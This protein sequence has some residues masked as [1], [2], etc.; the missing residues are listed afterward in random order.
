MLTF[1]SNKKVVTPTELA[2]EQVGIGR[3]YYRRVNMY[4]G[5]EKVGYL[6]YI[7]YG[8]DQWA[9]VRLFITRKTIF[10]SKPQVHFYDNQPDTNAED[11]DGMT[12]D[13]AMQ[14]LEELF[15][16]GLDKYSLQI[17]EK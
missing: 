14:Q 12:I 4:L 13:V 9:R 1:K 10:Q 17:K 11:I 3:S 5:D 8:M 7:T 16:T 6:E 15:Q 2:D